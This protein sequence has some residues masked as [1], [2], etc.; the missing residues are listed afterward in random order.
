[1]FRRL[2]L[3]AVVVNLKS[4]E[5]FQ[6]VL[7]RK[8]GGLIVLRNARLLGEDESRAVDGEVVIERDNV[9]FYQVIRP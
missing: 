4:G 3:K 7:W 1:M 2:K 9:A 5:A 6:G 8:R